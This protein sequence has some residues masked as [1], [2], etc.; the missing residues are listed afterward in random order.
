MAFGIAHL[1]RHAEL[2]PHLRERLAA[3]VERRHD[4]LA[5]TAGLNEEVFDALVLLAAGA[6]E[7]QAIARGHA[8]VQELEREMDAGRKKRL[9][10]LGFPEN[11][12]QSL[13]RLHTRNF[14]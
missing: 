6:F 3:A 2:D 9:A 4:A 1:R 13:S 12:A 14:M 7:P 8:L 5:H 10:R 11:E